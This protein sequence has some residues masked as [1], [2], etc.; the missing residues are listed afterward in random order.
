VAT[1]RGD[2]T[3][4]II[5]IAI[6][7]VLLTVFALIFRLADHQSKKI[8]KEYEE[9]HRRKAAEQAAAVNTVVIIIT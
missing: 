8:A 9:Y 5:E 1:C 2:D 3:A 6:V 7:I 4:M